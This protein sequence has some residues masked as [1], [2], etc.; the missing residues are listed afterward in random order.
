MNHTINFTRNSFI[1]VQYLLCGKGGLI[2]LG[3]KVK[4]NY[5]VLDTK[6]LLISMNYVEFFFFFLEILEIEKNG[7]NFSYLLMW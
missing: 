6:L 5:L 1:E 4:I 2:Y 7:Q 3:T